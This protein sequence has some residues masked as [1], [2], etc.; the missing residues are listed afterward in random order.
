MKKLF[1]FI[2]I[3]FSFS[4]ELK[5]FV[6]CKNVKNHTP[7]NIT[8]HFS[9]KDK[10]VYA[11]AYFSNIKKDKSIDFIWEKNVNN[12]WKLYA[13]VKLPIKKGYRWRTYSYIT[14]RGDYYQGKWRVG[15]FDTNKTI[16]MKEF[17]ITK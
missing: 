12:K 2:L 5:E 6:T 8:N 4:Y 14:V 9:I 17:N 15:L 16:A 13:V 10:K 7:I 3:C 11:F 1:I